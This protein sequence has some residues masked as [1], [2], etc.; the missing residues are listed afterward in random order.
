MGTPHRGSD[1]A[2]WASMLKE[3]FN[4]VNVG[5]STE[6]LADLKKGSRTLMQINSDFVERC[7]KFQQ[8]L[9]FF[10]MHESRGLMTRVCN[11]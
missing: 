9:S 2:K 10:E 3:L 7:P 8:I 5:S 6:L 4:K 11:C 1:M